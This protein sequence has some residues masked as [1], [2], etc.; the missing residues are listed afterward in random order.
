MSH[1]G[2]HLSIPTQH[3]MGLAQAEII[4]ESKE[5]I[6][7]GIAQRL[8]VQRP[9]CLVCLSATENVECSRVVQ[10]LVN[11]TA[12]GTSWHSARHVDCCH[13]KIGRLEAVA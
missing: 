5:Y 10:D 4:T 7:S 12:R 3:S 1:P 6:G 8:F 13:W 9:R 2:S 11:E